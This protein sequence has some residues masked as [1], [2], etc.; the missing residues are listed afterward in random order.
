ELAPQPS[1]RRKSAPAPAGARAGGEGKRAKLA[2]STHLAIALGMTAIF[3]V[4]VGL[5]YSS[6]Q[7]AGRELET[8]LSDE[9]QRIE[10]IGRLAAGVP[11]V[12]P[13]AR[14]AP[15]SPGPATEVALDGSWSSLLWKLASRTGHRI[16]LRR[17]ELSQVKTD[18]VP[19][20]QLVLEGNAQSVSAVRDWIE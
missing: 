18:G 19:P 3:A 7:R 14:R 10:Q 11:P 9:E 15:A 17:V 6:T 16:F 5:K 8:R 12:E 20:K 2:F 1:A 13:K 4:S